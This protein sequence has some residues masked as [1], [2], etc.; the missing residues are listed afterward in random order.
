MNPADPAAATSPV[1]QPARSGRVRRP[2]AYWNGA[3]RACLVVF[4][5]LLTLQSSDRIDVAKLAYLLVA[6]IAFAGCVIAVW[7]S[8]AEPQTVAMRPWLVGSAV[9]LGIVA[10]SL[11]VA[12]FQGSTISNWFRDA[13]AYALL[14]AA[15]WLAIDLAR[16]ASTRLIL[17]VGLVASLLSL[18]SFAVVWIQRRQLADLPIDRLAFPSMTLGAAAYCIAIAFAVRSHGRTRV[19]WILLSM[20]IV[21]TFLLTGTRTSFVLLAAPLAV[22]LFDGWQRGRAALRSGALPVVAQFAAVA[23]VLF[24]SLGGLQAGLGLTGAAD[25]SVSPGGG[26]PGPGASPGSGG[27]APTPPRRDLEDRFTTLDDIA[28]GRDESL[29][30]RLEVTRLAWQVFMSSPLFGVGLGHEYTYQASPTRSY[31]L[32]TLDTPAVVFSKFGALGL[33]LIAALVAPA[34]LIARALFKRSGSSWRLLTLIGY[35]AVLVALIPFGW[36][37]DDKGTAFALVFLLA[38]AASDWVQPTE[39]V[40]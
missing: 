9:I 40:A 32:L 35:G 10:L 6:G 17:G 33:L 37:P 18:A 24:V 20:V 5:G 7:R 26:P 19:A 30:L 34:W 16:S 3:T 29:R 11:P 15:P 25:P 28:S 31:T 36:P 4:G 27:P 38:L 8:R 39:A 21:A 14:A 13:A 22:V 12:I 23:M 1:G 2:L